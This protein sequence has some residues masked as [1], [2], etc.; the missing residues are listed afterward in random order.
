M[1]SSIRSLVVLGVAALASACLGEPKEQQTILV[2]H[3]RPSLETFG[4]TPGPSAYL[5]RRC[6]SLD[7][8]GQAGRPLLLRSKNGLRLSPNDTTG[9][10]PRTN[11]EV[12]AN[13][14]AVIG[15]EPEILASVAAEGGADPE[16]LMLLRKP[17][18]TERHKGGKIFADRSDGGYVCLI[19]WLRGTLDAS[20]CDSAP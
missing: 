2:E 12:R 13:Y 15:L 20:A 14:V 5:E 8:H 19:S 6:G 10:N 7:C 16:R 17:L 3:N 18:G 9:G 1:T 4:A 11:E